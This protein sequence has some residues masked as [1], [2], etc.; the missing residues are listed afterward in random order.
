MPILVLSLALALSA[1]TAQPMGH[2]CALKGRTA[3]S[4]SLVVW[5]GA[6]WRLKPP[7]RDHGHDWV[8]GTYSHRLGGSALPDMVLRLRVLPEDLIVQFPNGDSF[9]A[10]GCR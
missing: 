8:S 4:K 1:S 5:G 7:L 2:Y 10:H 3:A 6:V 9:T